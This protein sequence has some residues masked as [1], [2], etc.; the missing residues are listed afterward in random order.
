M[1]QIYEKYFNIHF[2]YILQSLIPDIHP[3]MCE[4]V[5]LHYPGG[6]SS[7]SQLIYRLIELLQKKR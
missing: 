6:R 3:I 4:T 2:I 7:P 1:L 5:E